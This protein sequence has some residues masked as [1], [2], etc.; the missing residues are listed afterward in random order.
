MPQTHAHKKKINIL[1]LWFS[2]WWLWRL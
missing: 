1:D 2:L